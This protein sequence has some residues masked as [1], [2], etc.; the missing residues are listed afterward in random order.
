MLKNKINR[1][2]IETL[3]SIKYGSLNLTDYDGRVY[4]FEGKNDGPNAQLTLHSNKVISNMIFKGDIAFADDYRNGLWDS[5]DLS[6]LIEFGLVNHHEL[7][8]FILAQRF[9]K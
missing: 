1:T 7:N 8:Q 9:S 6:A 4:T 3:K 5:E 2:F